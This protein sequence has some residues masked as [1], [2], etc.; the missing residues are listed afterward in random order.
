LLAVMHEGIQFCLSALRAKVPLRCEAG[1]PDI[2]LSG[3]L[4]E[5]AFEG[6]AASRPN[7]AAV[8]EA[9]CPS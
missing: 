3:L 1:W 7:P 4:A 2:G 8:R 9:A 6:A 5:D